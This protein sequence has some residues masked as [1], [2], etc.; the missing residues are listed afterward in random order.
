M[1]FN[2]LLLNFLMSGTS[3]SESG[4]RVRVKPKSKETILFFRIDDPKKRDLLKITG[5]ICDL[6]VFY[7]CDDTKTTCL[8]ELKRGEI[9][10]AI[11]QIINTYKTLYQQFSPAIE[12]RLNGKAIFIRMV[13]LLNAGNKA[14]NNQPSLEH[15]PEQHE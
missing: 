10:D 6:I 8:V 9:G 7:G 3:F 11:E 14:R 4:G 12:I 13:L 15:P 5:K 2:T 1:P